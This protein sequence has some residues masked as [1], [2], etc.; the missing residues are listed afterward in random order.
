MDQALT[1][2]QK[3]SIIKKRLNTT[4][5]DALTQIAGWQDRMKNLQVTADWIAHPNTKA[6]AALALE[7]IKGITATL[8]N[9]PHLTDAERNLLFAEKQAHFTYLAMLTADPASEID[10]IEKQVSDELNS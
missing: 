9:N 5:P 10:T 1:F 7:Q 3:I 8:G 2:D 4:A 6:L